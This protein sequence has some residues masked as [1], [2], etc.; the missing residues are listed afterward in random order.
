MTHFGCHCEQ[1]EAISNPLNGDCFVGK[2]CLLAMT[3]ERFCLRAYRWRYG[4]LAMTH[5]GCHCE[6]S[7]AISN[8]LNGDCFVGKNCLLAMT[9]ERF[10]LR[11]YRRAVW[12]SQN[13]IG[14]RFFAPL[15]PAQGRLFGRSE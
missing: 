2:N 14:V 10:C 11:A 13:D 12:S 9:G 8:P 5:F 7:E 3:G 1:S 4:V 15:R 6:Q